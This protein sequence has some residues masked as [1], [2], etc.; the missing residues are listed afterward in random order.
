[1]FISFVLLCKLMALL[2]VHFPQLENKA[3][4]YLT[5]LLW[6]LNKLGYMKFLAWWLARNM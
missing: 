6:G 5:E 4:M 1:M 3:N 2:E